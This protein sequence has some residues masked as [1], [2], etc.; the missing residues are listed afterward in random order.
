MSP[1]LQTNL[2]DAQTREAG[3]KRKLAITGAL[4]AGDYRD[5]AKERRKVFN[6]PA[7]VKWPQQYPHH[8]PAP[9]NAP[10]QVAQEPAKPEE[11]AVGNKLLAKMGWSDGEGLGKS[12]EGR[13]APIQVQQFA[14]RA[15]LG[16]SKGRD[17]TASWQDQKKD[18]VRI[19]TVTQTFLRPISFRA[20]DGLICSMYMVDY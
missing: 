12:G 10:Q 17:V 16:M 14:E 18:L 8:Q 19:F 6:Q 7:K 9:K 13:F 4:E 20:T 5:R 1:C 15:G 3:K 2:Q 11:P